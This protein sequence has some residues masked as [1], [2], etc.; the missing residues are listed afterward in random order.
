VRAHIFLFTLAY[1]LEWHMRKALAPLLYA[2]EEL[3]RLRTERDPVA[4]AEASPWARRKKAEK[5]TSDGLPLHSFSSVLQALGTLCRHRCS[6]PAGGAEST[7]IKLTEPNR[8][9]RRAFELLGIKE[10]YPVRARDSWLN[11]HP[12]RKL[13][14]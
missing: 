8:L 11:S 6:F 13:P 1:Y 12:Q 4:K 14:G 2:D 3:Q 7:L 5:T 9:Q 10:P